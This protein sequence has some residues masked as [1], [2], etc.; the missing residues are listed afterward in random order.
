[1]ADFYVQKAPINVLTRYLIL[2][3]IYFNTANQIQ[4]TV[5]NRIGYT[6]HHKKCPPKEAGIK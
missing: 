1:M 6:I 4:V 2:H 3:K 5:K